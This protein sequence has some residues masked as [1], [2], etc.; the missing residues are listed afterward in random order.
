MKEIEELKEIDP[1]DGMTFANKT[2][3]MIAYERYLEAQKPESERICNDF[4]AKNF[5]GK[6]GK[7]VSDCLA[8]AL[9]PTFD[10]KLESFKYEGHIQYTAARTKLISDH[11]KAYLEDL[12]TKGQQSRQVFNM[13]SGLDTRAF[14]DDGMKECTLYVE[15]DAKE[16]NDFKNGVLDG[17]KEAG[18]LPEPHCKRTIIS[19]DFKKESTADIPSKG[20]G[21]DPSGP[22]CWILEGLV[23][24][25]EQ[26]D[27]IQ[28]LTELSNLSA[29]DSVV[30]LNFIATSPACNPDEHD[31]LMAENGWEKQKR[32]M[33][34]DAEFN[35]G[36]YPP[37]MAPNVAY[38]FSFYKKL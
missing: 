29:K 38:G 36:K 5:I 15:C 8:C 6:Y 3:A 31:K 35:F 30:I 33:F 27:N 19:M 28:L 18:G 22:T 20:S 7:K 26:K 2:A 4:M 16:V 10:A 14:W 32:L 9:Q 25:L 34:G 17:L 11:V 12:K 1:N 21:F 24:Y 13:G 37:N 23:M